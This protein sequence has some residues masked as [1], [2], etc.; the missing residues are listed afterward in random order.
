MKIPSQQL[1][2]YKLQNKLNIKINKTFLANQLRL[3]SKYITK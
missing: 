2:D 1:E 3:Q